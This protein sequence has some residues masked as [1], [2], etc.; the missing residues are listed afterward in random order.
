V[1]IRDVAVGQVG[2]RDQRLV[3]DRDPVVSLILIADAL[4]DLDRVGECRLV[5]LDRLEA[6]LEAASFSTCLRYSSRVVAPTV[7]NSPRASIGLRIE[8]SIAPSATP[9]PTSVDLVDEQDDVAAGLDLLEDLLEALLEVAGGA[10]RRAHQV[11]RVQLLVAQRVG[12]SL[13][14][15]FCAR[16]STIAVLPTPGSPTSTGCSGL[17]QDLH[18]PLSSRVRPITGSSLRSR[19]LR[20]LR[21]N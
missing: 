4:G 1:A 11:E 19:H 13:L 18:D 8:A 16:P 15:I 12:T 7:C 9:A 2:H 20:E 3:G 10:P 14:T 21:P 5:D 17:R 6:A